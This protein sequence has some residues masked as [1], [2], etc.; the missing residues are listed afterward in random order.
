MLLAGCNATGSTLMSAP[1]T[2]AGTSAT[3]PPAIIATR[4]AQ[5]ASPLKR[6]AAGDLIPQAHLTELPVEAATT[7]A[8]IQAGGPFPFD[9]DGAVFGNFE[10]RLP[11]AAAGS[12]REYTV[13]TPGSDDRGARR[14]VTGNDETE[15]YY[16]DDHYE[17]FTEVILPEE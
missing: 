1:A 16:T 10:R 14:I 8:L 17:S 3:R 15:F 5:P 4:S 9:R 2:E 6:S 7:I 12:Y 11:A 13:V